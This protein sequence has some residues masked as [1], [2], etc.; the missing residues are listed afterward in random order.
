MFVLRCLELGHTIAILYEVYRTT[1]VLWGR[2]DEVVRFPAIGVV[3]VLGGFITTL[4]QVSIFHP[5]RE[6]AIE[7]YRSVVLLLGL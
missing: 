3:F 5:Q 2:S 7:C 6:G 1:I 4:V